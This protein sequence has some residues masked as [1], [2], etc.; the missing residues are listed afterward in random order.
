M[1]K[2]EEIV[3]SRIRGIEKKGLG[4]LYLTSSSS[5]FFDKTGCEQYLFKYNQG[6]M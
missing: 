3:F 6:K 4:H 2:E 5:Y 1:K